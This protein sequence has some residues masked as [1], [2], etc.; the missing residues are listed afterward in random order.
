MVLFGWASS[1]FGSLIVSLRPLRIRPNCEMNWTAKE[2]HSQLVT[3]I[4]LWI[5]RWHSL[6][7][8]HR[9]I[10]ATRVQMDEV[11]VT[12]YLNS[13][14]ASEPLKGF[15]QFRLLGGAEIDW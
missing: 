3:D 10:E 1:V 12:L 8:G 11:M 5:A 2:T 9:R 15:I 7:E 6:G 4:R 13:A 14:S